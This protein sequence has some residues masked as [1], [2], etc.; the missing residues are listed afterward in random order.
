MGLQ[1]DSGALLLQSLEPVSSNSRE[2]GC[3]RRLWTLPGL[4]VFPGSQRAGIA[5]GR[6][7]KWRS[8]IAAPSLH[9]ETFSTWAGGAWL[10]HQ[11]SLSFRRSAGNPGCP[12]AGGSAG[13]G[14]GRTLVP[15]G[16]IS[17]SFLKINTYMYKG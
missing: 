16:T 2:E 1:A 17:K 3:E 13:E 4:C 7:G 9:R 11:V 8:A 10:G 6:R 12:S 14:R 15:A 5:S